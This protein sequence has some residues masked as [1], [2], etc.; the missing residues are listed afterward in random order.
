[1]I[2]G[3]IQ[4]LFVKSEG[5]CYKISKLFSNTDI[6]ENLKENPEKALEALI[7]GNKRFYQG[8]AVHPRVSLNRL[9]QAGAEDQSK[10]V[11]ATILSCAD[12]RVPVERIFDTGVM[13]IFVVRVAGNVCDG[14]VTSSLEYGVVH[15]ETPVLVVL[16]HTQ[17]GAVTSAVNT[18]L[19]KSAGEGVSD[20]IKSML[21]LVEPAVNKMK[22]ET[23]S[24]EDLVN[25]VI[26][27]NILESLY[28][29]IKNSPESK[30]RIKD[31]KVKIVG[32]VYDVGTGV[33]SMLPSEII[34][35][36]LDEVI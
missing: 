6:N 15:L 25:K 27:A 14:V 33:V 35:D 11:F 26:E 23:D 29:F 12:S 18:I 22:E 24:K 30:K 32:A 10:H 36:F 28:N 20:N 8:K 21:K 19:D 2:F 4:N 3:Y 17:C 9:K 5:L 31:G 13:D 16:G 7:Q 34:D 1:M